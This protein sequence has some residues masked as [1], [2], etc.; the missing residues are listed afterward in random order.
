MASTVTNDPN[1]Y[2]HGPSNEPAILIL[3]RDITVRPFRPSDAESLANHGNDKAMWLNG[4]DVVPYPFKVT[5]GEEYIKR[6]TDSTKW[7]QSGASWT[8]PA[9]PTMYAIVR[10]DVAIGSIEFWVGDD[11]RARCANL[12]YWVGKEYWGQGIATEA[13]LAFVKWIW[14]T[15]PKIV[16]LDAEVYDFNVGS[17][18]VLKKAGF[19][20][21]TTLKCGVWKDGKLAGLELWGLVRPGL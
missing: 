3:S 4:P 19:E 17:G 5:D 6:A 10:N 7:M 15:F 12:G 18:K 21:L 16:R 1:A 8:G 9:R 14:E 2:A 11:V 20:H 13:L